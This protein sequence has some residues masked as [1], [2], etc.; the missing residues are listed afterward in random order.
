M[1]P[2]GEIKSSGEKEYNKIIESENIMDSNVIDLYEQELVPLQ[3]IIKNLKDEIDVL[4]AQ[5]LVFRDKVFCP[6]KSKLPRL[7][8]TNKK[9]VGCL[10]K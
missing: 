3:L 2:G 7:V 4:A 5:Q 1:G 8:H 9:C 6:K 10:R